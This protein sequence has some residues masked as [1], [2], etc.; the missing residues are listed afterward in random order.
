MG[1]TG[2]GGGGGA[3]RAA[4]ATMGAAA[5]A[6]RRICKVLIG[7]AAVPSGAAGG[8]AATLPV[9]GTGVAAGTG[10]VSSLRQAHSGLAGG[11]PAGVT[12]VPLAAPLLVVLFAVRLQAGHWGKCA[13]SYQS[14]GAV[15][16]VVAPPKPSRAW[17]FA[18]ANPR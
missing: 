8:A 15:L 5:N 4:A 12:F 6:T 18:L 10:I 1:D 16:T 3:G 13:G 11:G 7:W 2:R 14:S 17:V 9:A